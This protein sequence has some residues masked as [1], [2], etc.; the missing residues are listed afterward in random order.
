M[1]DGLTQVPVFPQEYHTLESRVSHRNVPEVIDGEE[2]RGDGA[3][4]EKAVSEKAVSEKAESVSSSDSEPFYSLK[5]THRIHRGL[6]P[7]HIQ[8]I[9]IGGT[10]GT[11]LFVQIA[12]VLNKGGPGSLFIAFTGWCLP[13]ICLTFTTAEMVTQ[14]PLPSPFTRLA[15]R[16]FDEAMEVASSWNFFILEATLVPF[17]ITSVTYVIE[18]WRS[19][20]SPW[21]VIL[22]QVVLY[23]II[24]SMCPVRWYGEVEFWLSIFKVVLIVGLLL[25]TFVTMVGGNPLNDAYGFRYWRDPGSF[26]E[27]LFTGHLGRFLG[28]ASCFSQAS[29]TIAGPDYVSMAAGE[30]ANPRRVL[31]KAYKGVLWRLSIFFMLGTLAM[32]IVCAS[33]DPELVA[34]LTGGDS[35][36]SGSPY[37]IAM[38]RLQIPVLP[39]IVNVGLIVSAFSAGN[40]YF[41]CASRT[42]YAMALRGHAPKVFRLCLPNGVPIIASVLVVAFAMLSFLQ[43][44]GSAN[45]VLSWIVSLGTPAELANYALMSATYVRF[46]FAMKAQG[47]DRSRLPFRSWFQPYQAYVSL[48]ATFCMTW[49]AGWAVFVAGNWST[50]TFVLSYVIIPFDVAVYIVWKLWKRPPMKRLSEIDLHSGLEEV[51]LHEQE[52]QYDPPKNLL[53]RVFRVIIGDT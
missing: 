3:A 40:S 5:P 20:F 26:S 4:S 33:D 16:F 11:A 41:F 35:G 12:S 42:L 21:M 28:F 24:N 8:L 51:D 6:K 1:T 18:Y 2:L 17:E 31:P 29:Y 13:V 49:L 9:G 15:G 37:V 27:Y 22:P 10:I 46:F 30:A 50:T 38:E 14:Y 7:R 23:I 52:C 32:G 53:D 47:V 36:A 25:F 45:T 44:S 43:L 48:F 34:A 39:H 19:D